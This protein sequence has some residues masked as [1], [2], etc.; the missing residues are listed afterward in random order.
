MLR[1]ETIVSENSVA[2]YNRK[3]VDITS[4]PNYHEIFYGEEKF[5]IPFLR[6]TDNGDWNT[7]FTSKIYEFNPEKGHYQIPSYN[8]NDVDITDIQRWN[9]EGWEPFDLLNYINNVF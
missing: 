2:R 1:R 3:C 5:R 4:N 6:K 7:K 9:G 8:L